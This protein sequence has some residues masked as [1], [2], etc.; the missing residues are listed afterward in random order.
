MIDKDFF[1][2]FIKV[3]ILHHARKEEI[4]GVEILDELRRHGYSLSPGT[5]YPTL[6]LLERKGYLKSRKETV[7]GKV[8][9]Y[10]A[11]TPAGSE[12]LEKSKMKIRELVDEVLGS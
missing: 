9:K 10:Y 4:Y 2:G 1:L 7:N 11:I 5:L 8:R 6:H 3:H 12:M